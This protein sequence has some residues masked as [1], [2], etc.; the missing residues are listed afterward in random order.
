MN[1]KSLPTVLAAGISAIALLL[2]YWY[3]KNE[4]RAAEIRKTQ[5]EIYSRVIRNITERNTMLGHLEQS[6]EYLAAKPEQRAH[7]EEQLQLKDLEL[8]TNEGER[9]EVIAFLGLFGADEAIDAYAEYARANMTKE[10]GD[11]G[12]LVLAL[13]RSVFKQK[14]HIKADEAYEAIW[15]VKKEPRKPSAEK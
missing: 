5:Q 3:Q 1:T 9:T 8:T 7:V 15:N 11:L 10:G 4:D 2:G 12:Q 13:R 6:P 14:T